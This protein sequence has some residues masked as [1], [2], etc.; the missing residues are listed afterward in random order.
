MV[1][2]D[3]REP[4]KPSRSSVAPVQEVAGT[5]AQAFVIRIDG[6]QIRMLER[7]LKPAID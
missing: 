1:P 6:G 3:K 4:D 2:K 7:R 5:V